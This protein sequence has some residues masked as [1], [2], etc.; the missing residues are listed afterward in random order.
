MRSEYRQWLLSQKYA[1]NT[2]SAQVHRASRVEEFHGDLDEHYATDR[3]EGLIETLRYSVDDARRNR[4]NPTSIPIEGDIRNNLASYKNAIERYRSFRD[5]DHGLPDEPPVARGTT[6]EAAEETGRGLSLERDMQAA[7]RV[8]IDQ[9]EPGLVII[10]DGAERSVDSGFIDITARDVTDAI[11]VIE[12]KV[13][14]AGQRAVAQ[15][16]SYM[17]DVASEQAG[18]RVRGILVASDFDAKAKSA[19]RVVPDLALRRYS[20][21]FTFADAQT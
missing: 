21:R 15:I 4:P 18:T 16:L 6:S 12:L 11:V 17:G 5:S 8:A 7:L 2:V 10:D 1:A 13:G 3:M 9:L 14:V 19:A 20:V